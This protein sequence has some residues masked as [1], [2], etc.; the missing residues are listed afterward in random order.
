MAIKHIQ[1]KR[2]TADGKNYR[3]FKFITTFRRLTLYPSL[4]EKKREKEKTRKTL[5]AP[6]HYLMVGLLAGQVIGSNLGES[7]P[8]FF[9]RSI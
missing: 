6:D 7:W 3:Q 9:S 1:A 8:G 5:K 2:F 4:L